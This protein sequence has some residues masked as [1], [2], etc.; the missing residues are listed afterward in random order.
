MATPPGAGFGA[1]PGKVVVAVPGDE[2][3]QQPTDT[4]CL[5]FPDTRRYTETL[6]DFWSCFLC[7]SVRKVARFCCLGFCLQLGFLVSLGTWYVDVWSEG[8]LVLYGVRVGRR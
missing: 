4:L 6:H 5:L 2:V 3:L 1:H 7:P 8:P